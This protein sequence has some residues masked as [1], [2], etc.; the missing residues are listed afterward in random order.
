[1]EVVE[2]QDFK[3]P[4]VLIGSKHVKV[5]CDG[6]GEVLFQSETVRVP[7]DTTWVYIAVTDVDMC[8]VPAGHDMSWYL[9]RLRFNAVVDELDA[10]MLKFSVRAR[11]ISVLSA[12]Q[13]SV[14]IWLSI[15]CFGKIPERK[16]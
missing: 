6:K 13:W 15:L 14:K 4:L 9:N 5:S 8:L 3:T 2:E 1:M 16:A 7:G 10:P 11:M 12:D